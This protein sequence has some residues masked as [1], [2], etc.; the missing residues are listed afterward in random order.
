MIP[1]YDSKDDIRDFFKQK[2]AE[3]ETFDRKTEEEF[4][5]MPEI[6]GYDPGLSYEENRKNDEADWERQK[7]FWSK[8]SQKPEWDKWQDAYYAKRSEYLKGFNGGTD[9][10]WEFFIMNDLLKI[11]FVAFYFE[12]LGHCEG[13]ANK[14]REM[15]LAQNLME[16]IICKGYDFGSD[17]L[18]Y[19]NYRNAHRFQHI[20][21]RGENFACRGAEVR[22]RKAWCLYFEWMKTH[23]MTWTD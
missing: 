12:H 22:F 23:L 9:Y 1:F 2:A 16:I 5:A 11:Q 14:A 21:Y 20:D 7:S 17:R 4:A 8:G 15:R 6:P 13:N 10:A 18:P 19:V 3:V